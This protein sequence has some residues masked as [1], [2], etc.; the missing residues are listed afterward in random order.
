[1]CQPPHVGWCGWGLSE[2]NDVG[3]WMVGVVVEP[4]GRRPPIY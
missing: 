1:M 3:Y 4:N 2:R